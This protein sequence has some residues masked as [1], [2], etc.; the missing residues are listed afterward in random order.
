MTDHLNGKIL[1]DQ[2]VPPG[3]PWSGKFD[4]LRYRHD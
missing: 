1:V 4:F 3:I 2:I